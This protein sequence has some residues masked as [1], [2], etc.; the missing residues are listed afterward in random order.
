MSGRVSDVA[1]KEVG[2]PYNDDFE[3]EV[4]VSVVSSHEV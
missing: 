4:A 3:R 2:E 1:A